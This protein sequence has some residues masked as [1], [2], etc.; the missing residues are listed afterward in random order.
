MVGALA[1][2]SGTTEQTP[3]PP[4]V[5]IMDIKAQEVDWEPEFIGQTAGFLEVEVRARVGGILEKRLFQEGQ[6]VQQ[7]TQLFQ[8]DP[9]PYEIGLSALEECLRRSKHSL[10]APGASMCAL[11]RFLKVMPSA[12][13]NAMRLKW[14]SLLLRLICGSPAPMSAMPK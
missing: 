4:L 6:F 10:S 5:E 11:P 7:G 14:P 9:V 3:P 8:I 1:C 2:S 13:A 12:N